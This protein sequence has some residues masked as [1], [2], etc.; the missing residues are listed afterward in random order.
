[1]VV[2]N[3]CPVGVTPKHMLCALLFLKSY[4]TESVAHIIMDMDE[5]T[6]R[7]WTWKIIG[8]LATLNMVSLQICKICCVQEQTV[9]CCCKPWISLN[10]FIS[11]LI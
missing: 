3:V 4:P 10:F 11:V 6:Y 9:S 2:T 8:L 7:T 5:K 1:M